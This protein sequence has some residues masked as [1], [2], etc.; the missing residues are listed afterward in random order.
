MAARYDL[1]HL[2]EVAST[3]DVA[4]ERFDGSDD[5]VLVIADR[6]LEGR[7]RQ[8][9]RWEQP[10]RALYSSFAFA[11]AW[12]PEHRGPL[13]LVVG[14]AVGNA[15]RDQFGVP[16]GLKWPNDV[17]LAGSKAGGILVEAS[18]D[19]IVAGVGINLFWEDPPDGATA[20]S[21]DDPGPD[22]TKRLA[23]GWADRFLDLVGLGFDGWPVDDYRDRCVTLGREVS[24]AS[25]SGTAIDIAPD[26]GLIV[27]TG[28]STTVIHAGEVH[29]HGHR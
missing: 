3:Q 23:T 9:R 26:G 14:I 25:G 16:V 27:D 12:L 19:R 7:G 21:S 10:D 1:V 24:W 18:G 4:A 17:M 29:L 5:D 28:G 22:A 13:P 11:S 8:G 15:I 20:L 2:T 6:Q